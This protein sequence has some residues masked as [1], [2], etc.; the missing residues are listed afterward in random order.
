[1][2]GESIKRKYALTDSGLRNVKLGSAWTAAVN[3][4]NFGS[5]ALL[6][7]LAQQL[8]AT[9]IDS[10]PLP[11]FLPYA[12][13]VVA[14]LIVS[15]ALH[16]MQY[17]Y[18][19]GVV[20]GESR[21]LRI[22]MA[23]KLR[24]LPLSFFGSRDL[25]DLAETIMSDVERLEHVWSHVLGYLYGSFVAVGIA[26]VACLFVDWRL[27]VAA[28]WSVPVAFGL[29][30]ALHGKSVRMSENAKAATLAVSEAV[31]E[32]LENARELR[33][34]NQEKRYLAGV[35]AKVDTQEKTMVSG[36][37]V[38]GLSVNGASVIMRLGV[39]TTILASAALVVSGQ[40]DFVVAFIFLLLVTRIYAPFD[41]ALA[42]IAELFIS[43][44]SAKRLQGIYDMPSVSGSSAFSPAGH[45][46]TFDD[47]RFAYQDEAVLKGVTFTACENQV[48]AL[49]GASGS[50]KST[51]GSLAAR[52]WDADGGQ[53]RLGGVDISTVDPE[54]LLRH[55]S[56]V[57]QD[58]VLF[59]DT[60]MENI[61]LGR[62]GATDEEVL[63]AARAAN[64]D[65]FVSGL[66]DG[67]DT[68]IGENGSKLSGGER[69]RISIARAVLKDAPVLL[70]DEATASLDAENETE[71]QLAL[72]R[73]MSGKT[74]LVIAHR[75][76]TV[77]NADKVVVLDD[78]QVIE[79]G[80]PADLLARE[81]NVFA[82]MG[83]L[84]SASAEWAF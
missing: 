61:R 83:Q 34:T 76:R 77:A 65:E 11:D 53:I 32:T 69:Q 21:A 55:Y 44:V 5:I 29:L 26:A 80:A 48:T 10:A 17:R 14:F 60:V 8:M 22:S 31:Q 52:L 2:L 42:L 82:R 45:D 28:F 4:A 81:D 50:G 75:M 7:M 57:F 38:V 24:T 27:T 78:G 72:S 36:E 59:D 25:S 9:I 66:P 56:I 19:Y 47:V 13:G 33:A 35:K 71:V 12:T 39:A 49:V 51:C 15:F 54:V 41:Q 40:I 62:K 20:Y 6:V 74:V 79:Q 84:Q 46:I 64:C 18:T 1:M 68:L 30:F 63:A 67:Y 58:V 3:L 43:E 16:V 70:L 73:L 37:L 23:D